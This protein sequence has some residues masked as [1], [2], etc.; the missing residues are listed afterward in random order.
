MGVRGWRK[1]AKDRDGW[2]LIMK[3]AGVLHGPDSQGCGCRGRRGEG[4]RERC[5]TLKE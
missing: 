3:E 1:I 4:E 2:K 5:F